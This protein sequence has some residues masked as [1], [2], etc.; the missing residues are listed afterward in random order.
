MTGCG[1]VRIGG[2]LLLA[3]AA[4]GCSQSAPPQSSISFRPP[5]WI[6][7]PQN[8][9]RF[10]AS[11]GSQQ[12]AKSAR[13]EQV[14]ASRKAA[15]KLQAQVEPIAVGAAE[16]IFGVG[17]HKKLAVTLA[18]AKVRGS[19]AIAQQWFSPYNEQFVLLTITEDEVR[20]NLAGAVE[21]SALIGD[22]NASSEAIA[23][24][25]SQAIE[26]AAK[27]SAA[28]HNSSERS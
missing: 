28:D 7:A 8:Y 3:A 12:I 14:E 5:E 2:V 16:A 13:L 26:Q 9:A 19:F 21:R 1:A 23:L 27:P 4:I 22:V 20:R 17:E 25:I 24:A 10:A 18:A 6:A 15:A 11:G